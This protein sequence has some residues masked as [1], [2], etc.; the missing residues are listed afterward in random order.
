MDDIVN[1]IKKLKTYT[2]ENFI[3][4]RRR[5]NTPSGKTTMGWIL[6]NKKLKN[7]VIDKDFNKLYEIVKQAEN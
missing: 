1:T 2:R 3:F 7:D 4:L 5:I 6:S